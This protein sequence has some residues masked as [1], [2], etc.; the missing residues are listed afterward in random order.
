M[1]SR[2]RF[3]IDPYKR[4]FYIDDAVFAKTD[5]NGYIFIDLSIS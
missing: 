4:R 1:S 3:I 2:F 5:F